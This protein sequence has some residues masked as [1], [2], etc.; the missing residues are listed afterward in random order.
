MEE[1]GRRWEERRPR[2]SM[3]AN[4]ELIREKVEEE[5]SEN[6]GTEGKRT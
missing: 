2:R 4:I 1:E 5:E 6:G 3:E